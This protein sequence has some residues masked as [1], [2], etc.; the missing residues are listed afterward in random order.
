LEYRRE[1]D[2]CGNVGE[3][4]R[5]GLFNARVGDTYRMFKIFLIFKNT[6]PPIYN[7]YFFNSTKR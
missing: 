3:E 2:D 6:T 4:A 7:K 1:E 5:Q